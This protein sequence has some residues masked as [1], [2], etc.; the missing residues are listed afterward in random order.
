MILTKQHVC[1]YP[2]CGENALYKWRTAKNEWASKLRIRRSVEN[3]S[4]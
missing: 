3:P 2:A 4:P 1:S